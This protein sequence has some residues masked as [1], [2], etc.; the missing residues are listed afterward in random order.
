MLS[1][2]IPHLRGQEEFRVCKWLWIWEGQVSGFPKKS[3][4]GVSWQGQFF[5]L[6]PAHH[7]GM[8]EL[9]GSLCDSLWQRAWALYPGHCVSIRLGSPLPTQDGRLLLWPAQLLMP[10]RSG[11]PDRSQE[12]LHSLDVFATWG[13]KYFCRSESVTLSQ[14]RDAK[15]KGS[16]AF[17]SLLCWS[18]V[19][20]PK[21]CSVFSGHFKWK[22][23]S[24]L[25]TKI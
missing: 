11:L 9:L 16:G 25:K 20:L 17:A 21:L 18:F 10:L 12:P 5:F 24:S 15:Y 19:C 6:F 13:E 7:L 14:S 3:G 4:M 23:I 8:R 22:F 1:A 2:Y